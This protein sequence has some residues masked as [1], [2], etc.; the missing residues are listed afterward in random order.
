MPRDDGCLLVFTRAPVPGEVKTRLV[1][2]LGEEGAARLHRWL[3]ERALQVA[4]ESEFAR[5]SLYCTPDARHPFL[6]ACARRYGAAL[7]V[8]VGADLGERM[9]NA[10]AVELQTASYAVL[11]G[12][13]CPLLNAVHLNTAGEHLRAGDD[14]ALGPAVDGGYVLIGLREPAPS[15][16]SGLPWGTDGVLAATRQQLAA[17]GWRWFELSEHWDLDRPEDLDRLAAIPPSTPPLEY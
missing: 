16:F 10:L 15:L 4:A 11:I 8:Q 9:Q 12:C 17:L 14:A 7:R 3:V 5:L 2:R 13:D 1:P 6:V